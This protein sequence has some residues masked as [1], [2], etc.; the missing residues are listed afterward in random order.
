[1]TFQK[2]LFPT[3]FSHTGDAALEMATALARDTGAMLYIV[4]VQE[5]PAFYG[6]GEMYYGMLDPTASELIKL[7]EEVKPSD[8]NVRY[9][10]RMLTGD[11]AG[12][13]V[14]FAKEEQMDLIVLGTHGRGGLSRLLMGSVAEA[15]VRRAECPVLTFKHTRVSAATQ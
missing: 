15:V 8:P 12:A 11:P 14:D 4:H 13:L 1:M 2:I 7:L 9:E 3:D 6:G 5:P 10:Q